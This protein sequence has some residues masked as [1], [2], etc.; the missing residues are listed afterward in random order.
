MSSRSDR[1]LMQ[2][3]SDCHDGRGLTTSKTALLLEEWIGERI[4]WRNEKQEFD[5]A[6]RHQVTACE[7]LEEAVGRLER[8]LKNYA[9]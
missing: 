9:S 3:A 1:E 2:I 5:S 7:K 8:R 4:K 6:L